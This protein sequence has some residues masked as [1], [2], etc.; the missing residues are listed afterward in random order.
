MAFIS[1]SS[2]SKI[3]GT[4]GE[5]RPV[6]GIHTITRRGFQP[7]PVA[8]RALKRLMDVVLSAGALIVLSPVLIAL[9]VVIRLESP[10]P[11]IFVQKRWGRNQRPIDVYKFRTM[12]MDQGDASGVTQTVAN[13]PRIT[14]VGTFLRKSNLDEL[15]QLFNVLQGTMSLVGPR[16][17][18]IGMLAGGV[19]YEA[20]VPQYHDRHRVRPG[21]TGIA[22]VNGLRGPT[23]DADL[24]VQR[25]EADLY[26]VEHYSVWLDIKLILKTIWIEFRGGTGS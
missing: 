13:D 25:I 26:Y 18:P 1:L 5:A 23:V 2:G 16:C 3:Y 14:R 8:Q 9:W 10:G 11:A 7:K 20:L 21:L 24:A 4:A 17:H 15:P 12:R 22:Q 6:V 19:Q